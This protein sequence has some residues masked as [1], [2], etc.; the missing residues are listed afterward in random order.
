LNTNSF[1]RYAE[2]AKEG[3]Q[4]EVTCVANG[5]RR[6]QTFL[7]ATKKQATFAKQR[8]RIEPGTFLSNF[9]T[10]YKHRSIV[11]KLYNNFNMKYN[12]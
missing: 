11:F 4:G 8:V 5:G 3:S 9:G 2:G 12:S 1:T 10:G 7:T 6:T